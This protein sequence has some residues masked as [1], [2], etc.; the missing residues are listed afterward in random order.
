MDLLEKLLTDEGK[1]KAVW[2]LINAG[3]IEES[4][5][6]P[7]EPVIEE[8][9]L[10]EI[11]LNIFDTIESLIYMDEYEQAYKLAMGA[12]RRLIET[13]RYKSALYVC[14]MIG[15]EIMRREILSDGLK[16]YESRG[17]F[18]N[19]MDFALSLV[20]LERYKTYE[21]LYKLY[22]KIYR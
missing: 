6:K 10:S 9:E 22:S 21:Y 20:D 7:E 16:Y 14:Q 11:E 17:D 4:D 2:I 5:I 13:G 19:A 3:I 15:D 8:R 1:R 12:I 18:K